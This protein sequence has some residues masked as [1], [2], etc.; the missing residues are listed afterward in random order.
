M[1]ELSV[2]EG[3]LNTALDE[4]RKCGASRIIN[5][6]LAMGALSGIVPECVQEY[7]DLLSEDTAAAGARLE[8]D[9]IP[10]ML[11]CRDCGNKFRMEHMRL[12]CPAC[13][14]GKVD[15]IQGKEFYLESMEVET[16]IE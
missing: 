3:I 2:T 15:I 12:R 11:C 5:I 6:K 16:E 13:S 4:A 9:V 10:A 1:H 7:F 14:S 8:F